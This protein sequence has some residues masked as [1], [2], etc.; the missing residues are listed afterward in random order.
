MDLCT[1]SGLSWKNTHLAPSEYIIHKH[2]LRN[3][4][5]VIAE[6]HEQLKKESRDNKNCISAFMNVYSALH[7]YISHKSLLFVHSHKSYNQQT[8]LVILLPFLFQFPFVDE[9]DSH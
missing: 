3:R 5:P 1:K 2:T 7:F 4:E 6:R 8:S 9:M